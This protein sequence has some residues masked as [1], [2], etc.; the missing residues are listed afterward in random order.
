[1]DLKVY[2]KEDTF[3][4]KE[5]YAKLSKRISVGDETN[6]FYSYVETEIRIS[7]SEDGSLHF[8]N[9]GGSEGFIYFYP[10]QL[11]H[12]KEALDIALETKSIK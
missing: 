10:D 3:M 4:E 11:E 9:C 12:V 7:V 5:V 6:D 2:N 1:M 8:S